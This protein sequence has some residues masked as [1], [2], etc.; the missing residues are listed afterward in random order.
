MFSEDSVCESFKLINILESNQIQRHWKF[1]K[2]DKIKINEEKAI[3]DET[4]KGIRLK[5]TILSRLGKVAVGAG[6]L[7]CGKWK[8]P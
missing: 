3:V 8:Q 7:S 5:P 2:K 6:N 4:L 1:R